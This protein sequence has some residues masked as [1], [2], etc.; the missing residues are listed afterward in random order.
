MV[1][2]KHEQSS[3]QGEIPG[4]LA[5]LKSKR[6]KRIKF[7]SN[8]RFFF[9]RKILLLSLVFRIIS[10]SEDSSCPIWFKIFF[11][12]NTKP[13]LFPSPKYMQ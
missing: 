10:H 9:F 13:Q 7:I 8:E 12:F 2:R 6:I 5:Q 1:C 4:G 11:F 3:K